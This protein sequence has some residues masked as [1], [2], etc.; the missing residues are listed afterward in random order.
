M[1]SKAVHVP[2]YATGFR[3]DQLEEALQQI[4]PV[5]VRY[6]ATHYEVFRGLDDRY[7]FQQVAVFDPADAKDCWNRYWNGPEFT[8]FRTVTSGWWQVPILYSW[9]EHS[10][11]G[12]A[13]G[14]NG[15][16]PVTN[17]AAVVPNGGSH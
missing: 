15:V 11:S 13:P 2:W 10:V 16:A 12:T 5:A 6:G 9:H 1:A 8:R 7:K 4:A 3:G 14:S 17:G